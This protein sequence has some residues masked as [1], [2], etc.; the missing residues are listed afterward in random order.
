MPSGGLDQHQLAVLGTC[1]LLLV[2]HK[3]VAGL[4]VYRLD[5]REVSA[6]APQHAEHPMHARAEAF[7]D[8]R[9]VQDGAFFGARDPRQHALAAAKRRSRF[10]AARYDENRWRGLV[11]LPFDR[12]AEEIAIGILSVNFQDGHFRKIAGRYEAALL[13]AL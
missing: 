8:P 12:T 7:D 5:A 10:V 1:E 3:G 11:P 9:L 13:A 6:L 4:A 2:D